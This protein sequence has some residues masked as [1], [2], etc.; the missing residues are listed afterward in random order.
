MSIQSNLQQLA[1]QGALQYW[2]QLGTILLKTQL[3]LMEG[4]TQILT[5]AA[6]DPLKPMLQAWQH[7]LARPLNG[8]RQQ[9]SQAHWFRMTHGSPSAAVHPV[10]FSPN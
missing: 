6:E 8:N 7:A 10:N 3:D 4:G 5:P 9:A 2:Q 1:V